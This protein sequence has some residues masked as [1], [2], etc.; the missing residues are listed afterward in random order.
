MGARADPASLQA[1][2]RKAVN[3]K[4]IPATRPGLLFLLGR[5]SPPNPCQGASTAHSLANKQRECISKHRNM[6]SAQVI[7]S[8]FRRP[9]ANDLLPYPF[10]INKLKMKATLR[11][12]SLASF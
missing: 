12:W 9:M 6:P 8:K 5:P 11:N 7:E 3:T 2:V 1:A 4:T 10:G